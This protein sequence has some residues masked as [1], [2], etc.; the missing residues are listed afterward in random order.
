MQ[1][2]AFAYGSL[3]LFPNVSKE[4]VK[5]YG[6]V[7]VQA[8]LC[9]VYILFGAG[10]I[11][12][13]VAIHASSPVFFE[14]L[15]EAVAAP[16]LFGLSALFGQRCL[17]SAKDLPRFLAAGLC[18]FGNQMTSIVGLKLTSPVVA[19]VWQSSIAIW[20]ASVTVLA[21]CEKV[22][23][24]KALG[25][26]VAVAGSVFI[27]ISD[28]HLTG[29]G[30]AH[31]S[32]RRW[33][34]FLLFAKCVCSSAYMGLMKDLSAKYQAVP[35]LANCFAIAGA[36]SLAL[37]CFISKVPS[38]LQFTCWSNSPYMMEECFDGAWRVRADIWGALTYEVIFGTL[39]AWLLLHWASQQV[40]ASEAA[41]FATVQPATA[42]AVSSI[43]V[44]MK[45]PAWA[46]AHGIWL[47]GA[48]NVFGVLLII[49]G[50]LL[51]ILNGVHAQHAGEAGPMLPRSMQ[52]SHSV[53]HDSEIAPDSG[54]SIPS[55]CGAGVA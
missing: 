9:I 17:P 25:I 48:R 10:V 40:R 21:G 33:G 53:E 22:S 32:H 4:S 35:I 1:K 31:M 51:T 8:V 26:A 24:Q 55:A 39:V 5:L 29:E 34:H 30:E 54:A 52:N 44:V 11:I 41:A 7:S 6:L 50:L 18:L 20:M 47:P 3:D 37:H 15:R 13:K 14:L 12:V 45:G 27:V 19:T 2:H 36:L 42:C 28:A 38:L 16:L 46:M 23:V 43:L 49:V